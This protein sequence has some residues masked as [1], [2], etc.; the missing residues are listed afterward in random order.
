MKRSIVTVNVFNIVW[1][2]EDYY[3][4]NEDGIELADSINNVA[5]EV[6][7][8]KLDTFYSAVEDKIAEYLTNE[9]A[10]EVESF[11][12]EFVCAEEPDI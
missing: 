7:Y 11:D 3:K 12:W 6:V 9:Y 5:L 10:I 8:D 4:Y 1:N 2:D